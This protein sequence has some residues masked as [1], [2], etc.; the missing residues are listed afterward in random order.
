MRLRFSHFALLGWLLATLA[1]ATAAFAEETPHEFPPVQR[2]AGIPLV[3]NGYGERERWF[4]NVYGCALY[5]PRKSSSPAFLMAPSTPTAIRIL[6][7]ID[8][9]A[10]PPDRWE[11]TFRA[12]LSRELF[13]RLTDA[14][15]TIVAGDELLFAYAPRAGT[16]AY[17]NDRKLFHDPGHG[18][19]RGLLE[20]WL[21]PQPVSLNLRRLLLK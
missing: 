19:M 11:E 9:P 4:L 1:P 13:H 15:E 12:E 21:G 16:T 6:V 17:L 2:V 5:A 14:Y 7:R 8:P 20:Q 3:L 10:E 18:L